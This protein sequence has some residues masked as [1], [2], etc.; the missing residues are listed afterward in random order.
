MNLQDALRKTA[1]YLHLDAE[2]LIR[3]ADET[4]KGANIPYGGMSIERQEGQFLYAVVRALAPTRALEIGCFQGVSSLH[5]LEGLEDG[6]DGT[7]TSIDLQP[8]ESSGNARWTTV[9][10]DATIADLPDADFV[11]EDSDH[12]NPAAQT[13]LTKVKAL[14]PRVV[15]SHDYYSH[16]VYSDDE[17]FQGKAAFDAVFGVD[18]VLGVRW[19]GGLRGFGVWL[20]PAWQTVTGEPPKAEVK[21]PAPKRAVK[22]P[23]RKTPG[24]KPKATAKS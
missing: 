18:N 14:G 17:G 24:R 20:N 3:Y 12:Q 10:A 13:I 19:T 23:P 15:I 1:D 2:T 8:V 5:I 9:Q 4:P 16:E 11:Y 6:G 21:E 7:L 22:A